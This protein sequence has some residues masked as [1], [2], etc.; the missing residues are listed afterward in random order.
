M[1]SRWELFDRSFK[2]YDPRNGPKIC[3]EGAVRTTIAV[4]KW[5]NLYRG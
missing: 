2:K 5:G 3:N 1:G 4:D